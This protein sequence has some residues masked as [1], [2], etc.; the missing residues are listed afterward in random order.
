MSNTTLGH[1]DAAVVNARLI[2]K[3]GVYLVKQAFQ[4]WYADWI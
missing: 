4:D 3:P 2:Q 1:D